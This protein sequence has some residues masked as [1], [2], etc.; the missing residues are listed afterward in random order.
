MRKYGL[1]NFEDLD[2]KLDGTFARGLGDITYICNDLC[3]GY[4]D[5]SALVHEFGHAAPTS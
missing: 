1:I 4:Y 5:T 3:V 2:T